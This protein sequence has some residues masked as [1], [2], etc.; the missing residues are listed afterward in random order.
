[1]K[2]IELVSEQAL[3]QRLR[4]HLERRELPDAFLYTGAHGTAN[5]LT[6]ESSK[7]FPIAATLTT[8]MEEHARSIA[9]RIGSCRD[10]VSVGAGDAQKELLLLQEMRRLA[11]PVCHV[12][13]VSSQ[14]VDAALRNL[15]GLGLETTGI[16]A[17]CE[18][19][20]LLA[21]YWD[22]PILLCLLGNNFCNYEPSALL[23]LLR[24]NLGPADL[25][26]LDSSLLPNAARDVSR[27]QREVE[28]I[29]NTPENVRLNTAPLVARG[30]DPESCRF[31]LKLIR[32]ESPWGQTYRTQKRI[33]ISK[34][35][36]VQCGA[37]A[38][39]FSAGEVIEMGFTYKYRLEQ[40]RGHLEKHGFG[41]VESW[42]DQTGG[43]MILLATKRTAETES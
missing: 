17:F 1:M 6:L 12:I 21:P 37:E 24:R 9:C 33:H 25:L 15:S 28:E 26:L 32:V 27:W 34:R 2:K 16:V 3:E 4:Y 20:D 39:T 10:L 22:R 23:P 14:M 40:L 18:D 29:Y 19:L 30:M 38:V 11:K 31:E 13:D 35:A 41:I 42:A 36:I 7:R 5:W 8:L 43:N